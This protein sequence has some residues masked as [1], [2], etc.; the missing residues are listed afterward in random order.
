MTPNVTELHSRLQDFFKNTLIEWN[1]SQRSWWEHTTAN[2]R[3][4]YVDEEV[5]VQP[6]VFPA[7]AREFLGFEVGL[8]LAAERTGHGASNKPDFTPADRITHPFVFETK[9]TSEG[10][11]LE[12]HE[13]Q[14]ASYL[15][16]PTRA[17]MLT[18]VVGIVVCHLAPDGTIIRDPAIDLRGLVTLRRDQA[19]A[20]PM[21]RRF[22]ELIERFSRR[23][24]T[25]AEK[26][27]RIR[28]AP[29]WVPAQEHVD[30]DWL[31][32]RIQSV[33]EL[34]RLEVA[35]QVSQGA[36]SDPTRV[37]ETE[38]AAILDELRSLAV[39]LQLPPEQAA[40]AELSDFTD[41]SAG[42]PADKACAQYTSHVAYW[43]ATKLTLVRIWE[44]IGLIDPAILHDGGFDER[45]SSFGNAI[46][47]VIRF[48]FDRAGERYRA[49]FGER[50]TYAWYRPSHSTAVD[51][52]YELA[53]TY[54]G[55]VRSDVLGRVYE[56]TLQRIDRKLL[57]QYYTP[58]DVI[59]LIWDLVLR[60]DQLE[61]AA[62][63]EARGLRVLD[64][65]TGS[66]GFL[67]EAAARQRDRFEDQRARGATTSRQQ[68][69]NRMILGLDGIE[70]Q[71]F[72]AFL[73]ELN[74]LI[75][76]SRTLALEPSLRIAELG[77]VP[78]D[79]LSLHQPT[80][81]SFGMRDR[82]VE[83]IDSPFLGVSERF[84]RAEQ[85]R[86]P[87]SHNSW[88]DVAIGNPP[89]IGE[90]IGARLWASARA[91]FPYWD[92]FAAPHVDYLY[93]FL[94]VGISKLRRGG[95][96]G[97]ITTEYWL[98]AVGARPLRRYILERCS[99]ERLVLFRGMR[100]FP[101]APGQHSLV[102]VGERLVDDDQA[103]TATS[104]PPRVSIYDGTSPSVERRQAIVAAMSEGRN[105][106]SITLRTFNA[107]V[108]PQELGDGPWGD[109]LL[110]GPQLRK[111]R[112]MR[113]RPQVL[114]DV[115]KGVETTL[116]SLSPANERELSVASLAAVRTASGRPGIQ[117]LDPAEVSALGTLT[118]EERAIL[119]PWVNT[120]DVFPYACVL[121]DDVN[122][123]IYLAK[124]AH[125]SE[126][127]TDVQVVADT[128]FPSNMPSIAARMLHFRQLLERAT[129]SRGERR[130]WWTL[131]RPRA[132]VLGIADEHRKWA[133]Y[134]VTTRWGNGGRIVMALTPARAVPAS[135]LHV[136]RVANEMYE[137]AYLCALF[138]STVFQELAETL[139]PGQLRSEELQG[140]AP[141]DLGPE[142]ASA[143]S[144]LACEQAELICEMVGQIA[145]SFP[146]LSEALRADIDLDVDNSTWSPT[147]W[148]SATSGT[149]RSVSWVVERRALGAQARPIAGV[150]TQH[151]IEGW[152]VKAT[153]EA[154]SGNSS[155][156]VLILGHDGTAEEADA[157]AA[158]VRGAALP[159]PLRLNQLVALPVPIDSNVLVEEYESASRTL[160]GA[161]DDY[162]RRREVIDGLIEG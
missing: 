64:I 121:P 137:A 75:Q 33:V 13:S 125:I 151:D 114:L 21:A 94:I 51:A 77:I 130:P 44:D 61:E 15:A 105:L 28:T 1:G 111:R 98:R 9:G 67:V 30:P 6:R 122:S 145:K 60:D 4:G 148:P 141:P 109:L 78:A 158:Y 143:L 12:G 89:Y 80:S 42:S 140:M 38:R 119:R 123:V 16:H 53:T 102:V 70:I 92:Q 139:P 93:A 68:W 23:V 86:D 35:E 134:C 76:A 8:N 18:N 160:A 97:F 138:N 116:N 3:R 20:S 14:L 58:R 126:E 26:V 32:A 107:A 154:V 106:P 159:R 48:A 39:R 69:L 84:E 46:H 131:H 59:S 113:A 146:L 43:L 91:R 7:F 65:A 104:P 29:E 5:L 37:T 132:D 34:F 57:G 24:L 101:D 47:E 40:S 36:L 129:T 90:K 115:S 155:A 149:I 110:T 82:T 147:A 88:F 41:A 108:S 2:Y 96:F 157:L 127:L 49:L 52:V 112:E 66:G 19:A 95:R 50:P 161:L 162:R 128:P 79:T 27:E 54:F 133:N 45:M 100:L 103:G 153:S 22:S 71:R 150:S 73:A 156:L 10:T 152:A 17:V 118:A 87:A 81:G 62:D 85:I 136:V 55:D 99:I 11:A 72:S 63:A 120:K 142:R 56:N 117:L 135:G 83:L 74:L 124:P 144:S 25:S 31:G